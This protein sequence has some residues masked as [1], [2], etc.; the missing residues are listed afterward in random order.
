MACVHQRSARSDLSKFSR[1][2]G[3][4]CH[5]METTVSLIESDVT[6][7]NGSVV[8]TRPV[9]LCA[10]SSA[11]SSVLCTMLWGSYDSCPSFLW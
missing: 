7:A 11:N 6:V 1:T 5:L 8:R 3:P 2:L 4:P 9:R 10:S